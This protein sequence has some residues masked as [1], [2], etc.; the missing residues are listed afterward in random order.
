[1]I[2]LDVN[3][4]TSAIDPQSVE[5]LSRAI[6]LPLPHDHGVAR[7][8]VDGH[9][10]PGAEIDRCDIATARRISVESAPLCEIARDAV[11]ET[12]EW[13]G[14]ICRVLDSIA[15]DYRRGHDK[16]ATE[17]LVDVADALHVLAHLLHGIGAGLL[18]DLDPADGVASSWQ[19]AYT[20]LLASVEALAS[21]LAQ[22]SGGDPV[23]MADQVGYALPR[24]LS[25]FRDLLE[26]V[27]T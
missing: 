20:A 5:E 22:P 3:G 17:R 21:S 27:G 10:V 15:G 14:R 16:K 6:L 9:E 26:R 18:R 13:I 8:W 24:C 12:A 11:A 7:V 1:M 2:Q 25:T 4:V 19:H 23:A